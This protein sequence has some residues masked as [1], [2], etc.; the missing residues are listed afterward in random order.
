MNGIWT[1][2]GQARREEIF[3]RAY[4]DEGIS[5]DDV[6]PQAQQTPLQLARRI[7]HTLLDP[8]ATRIMVELLCREAAQQRFAAT[9]AKPRFVARCSRR[10]QGSGVGFASVVGFSLGANDTEI[11]VFE[12]RRCVQLG[13]TEIDIVLAIGARDEVG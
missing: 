12:A 10:L 4:A 7:D 11:R 9:C 3:L 6:E 1:E 5:R 13:A 8:Q 2:G